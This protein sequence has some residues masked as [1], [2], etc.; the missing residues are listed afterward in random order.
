MSSS[1]RPARGLIKVLKSDGWDRL[2][3]INFDQ[4]IQKWVFESFREDEGFDLND[5]PFAGLRL[6]SVIEAAKKDLTEAEDADILAPNVHFDV[7]S[8][9]DYDINYVLTRKKF[10]ELTAHLVDKA[11]EI[12]KRTLEQANMQPHEFREVLLV[13]GMSRVPAVREA[14]EKLFGTGKIRRDGP[15]PDLAVAIGASIKGALEDGRLVG[16][17]I[18]QSTAKAFGIEG[19]QGKLIPIVPKGSA[20]GA[21]RSA[22][23]TNHVDGQTHIPIDILQGDSLVAKECAVIGRYEHEIKPGPVQSAAVAVDFMIDDN[24]NLMA[25][26]HDL[27]TARNLTSSEA[28]MKFGPYFA[29]LNAEYE[30]KAGKIV[31]QAYLDPINVWTG[32][33]GLSPTLTARL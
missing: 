14:V 20:Y 30:H 21:L 9:Q 4:V 31:T 23:L 8:G 5:A 6:A 12:T 24:G 28:E 15:N 16:P 13:G 2:G 10:N 18:N 11:I 7:E 25:S 22:I 29:M 33:A 32:P 3:G 1:C 27:D 17:T 26:G 19:R